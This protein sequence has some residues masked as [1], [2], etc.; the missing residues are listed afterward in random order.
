[1]RDDGLAGSIAHLMAGAAERAAGALGKLLNR[2]IWVRSSQLYY[3]DWPE[4]LA[5]SLRTY[6]RPVSMRQ[7]AFGTESLTVSLLLDQNQLGGLL[8]LLMGRH[9]AARLPELDSALD[10]ASLDSCEAD[11]LKET[12]NIVT[13]CCVSVLGQ[14]LGLVGVSM[15]GIIWSASLA[16]RLAQ[17]LPDRESICG[18][19]RL[20]VR[21]NPLEMD[22]MMSVFRSA[23][24]GF[25]PA[26]GVR[27][28]SA[29]PAGVRPE[30][31]RRGRN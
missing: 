2:E 28:A 18:K 16:D 13:G 15:P 9:G 20:G 19:S 21:A 10:G 3:G 30:G 8:D 26:A 12:I 31:A 7:V 27:E 11:S 4:P 5:D 24:D 14:H 23:Q 25:R 29:A 17:L 1:M 6:D 22:L